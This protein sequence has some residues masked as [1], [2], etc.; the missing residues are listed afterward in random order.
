MRYELRSIG[1]WSFVKVAFFV[2]LVAGFVSGIL[3]ALFFGAMMAAMSQLPQFGGALEPMS[4]V[5]TGVMLV[6]FPIMGAFSA[7][8]F[9]TLFGLLFVVVY[10]LT[11]KLIGGLELNFQLERPETTLEPSRPQPES[12]TPQPPPPPPP[13]EE[14][15]RDMR[16]QKEDK[17]EPVV[18]KDPTVSTMT[19]PPVSEP[20]PTEP[21]PPER[22]EL[23]DHE[24]EEEKER[25]DREG[26]ED[27]R[28][29]SRDND[30]TSPE[31]P[32]DRPKA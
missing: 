26:D 14:G 28:E 15:S 3:Y 30:D 4:G 18:G 12:G 23:P 10:N 2:N 5:G 22:S 25:K 1:I 21:I 27:N 9:G 31:P 17:S 16:T 11:A 19:A 32:E 20:R 8:F 24:I 13:P 7:A 29:Q 6:L